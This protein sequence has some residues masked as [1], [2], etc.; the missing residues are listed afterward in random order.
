MSDNSQSTESDRRRRSTNRAMWAGA[1]IFTVL[2]LAGVSLATVALVKEPASTN[3]GVVSAS[4]SAS[5]TAFCS[6]V[7]SLVPSIT[8][9]NTTTISNN[10]QTMANAAPTKKLSQ[11]LGTVAV[12]AREVLANPKA[13]STL[14][15]G[16][17]SGGLAKFGTPKITEELK[18]LVPGVLRVIHRQCPSSLLGDLA[19]NAQKE[20]GSVISSDKTSKAQAT[21]IS[22][23]NDAV[24]IAATSGQAVNVTDLNS[25]VGEV[26]GVKLGA[27]S[28]TSNLVTAA[29]FLVT[30]N[31]STQ[32]VVVKF[33]AIN[34][35]PTLG[36]S[37]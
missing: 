6:S 9:L 36:G 31:N 19:K 23:A 33:G 8:T 30:Q 29:N 20:F 10:L 26:S 1:S 14:E 35:A 12:L 5:K 4:W 22:V 27:I 15:G 34:S 13:L 21:A 7:D 2:G 3:S 32:C 11:E 17:A 28:I 18:S 16:R 37:C 25:A 24:A